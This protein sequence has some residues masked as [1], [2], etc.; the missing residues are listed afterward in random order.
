MTSFVVLISKGVKRSLSHR[1][2]K[3]NKS[4]HL[5]EAGIYDEQKHQHNNRWDTSFD[6]T[7]WCLSQAPLNSCHS[8]YMWKSRGEEANL[9]RATWSWPPGL[10]DSGSLVDGDGKQ[11]PWEI[12]A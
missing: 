9:P 3:N 4:G 7:T 11:R 12:Q 6:S 1:L 10:E 8:T 5:G 2:Y